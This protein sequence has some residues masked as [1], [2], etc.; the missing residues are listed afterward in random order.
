MSQPEWMTKYNEIGQKGEEG[1]TTI[2]GDG[3][4]ATSEVAPKRD[5]LNESASDMAK[6]DVGGEDEAAAPA[7]APP[8]P[9]PK[10]K[11]GGFLFG[12]GGAEK[13]EEEPKEEEA[14]EINSTDDDDDAAAMFASAANDPPAPAPAAEEDDAAA[15]FANAAG[16]APAPAAEDDDAAAMFASA[17]GDAPAPAPAAEDDDAAAM[18]ANAGT[19]GDSNDEVIEEE[20]D[21]DGIEEE[22]VGEGGDDKKAI[23]DWRRQRGEEP[24]EEGDATD[25]AA[26]YA[27]ADASATETEATREYP[28][29]PPIDENDNWV[30]QSQSTEEVMVDDDG[31]EI[32]EEDY[33]VDE[34]GNEIL[35]EGAVFVD[36]DGNEI[37]E[38]VDQSPMEEEVVE[39]EDKV[40]DRDLSRDLDIK[41]TKEPV[42]LE[43][44]R[45]LLYKTPQK[46][47]SFMSKLLPCFV[48]IAIIV[49]AL[50]V[51]ILV[52]E[53]DVDDRNEL[54]E[55]PTPAF[56]P[57]GPTNIG[58]IDVAETTPLSAV[59]GDCNIGAFQQPHVI[60]QCACG[61]TI[62]KIA[63][64]V[65]ARYETLVPWVRTMFDDWEESA[66]SCSPRNQ[67]LVW[68][69]TGVNLGGEISDT[70]RK[71]RYL[72]G[73]LYIQQQGQGWNKKMNWLTEESLCNWEGVFCDDEESVIG[74]DVQDNNLKNQLTNGIGMYDF[75]EFVSFRR[76][77]LNGTIP[78]EL[79]ASS[80]L[81]SID[82]YDNSF[83][84]EI[85]SFDNDIPL[86]T[87]HVGKN[88]LSGRIYESI[89]N[90]KS[91]KRLDLSHNTL[92]GEIPMVLFDLAL[93]EL[94]INSNL[95]TGTIHTELGTV[96][97][98]TELN[99]GGNPF[100]GSLPL[101]IGS[102]T[103]LQEFVVKDAPNIDGRIP[104]SFGLALRNLIKVVISG[105][106]INGNVPETFGS[107]RGLEH[108]EFSK[109]RLRGDLS[110][111]FGN[112]SNLKVM[113]LFDND[114]VGSIPTEFGQ[115][116]NL[117]ALLL[118]DNMITGEI[119]SQ[120]SN[121][122][123][124]KQLTLQ[125]NNMS[126]RSPDGVCALRG[127]GLNVFVVDCPI[128]VG[129]SFTGVVCDTPECCTSCRF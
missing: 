65:L 3:A 108:M 77:Q 109:N 26:A 96:T 95:L 105:T 56:L 1:V 2:E 100:T 127:S 32:I 106:S 123:N 87:L 38:E 24:G 36:E 75:L 21:D 93:E 39:E 104:A 94:D 58:I 7:P 15:M 16:P 34:D 40:E 119:P 10:P 83:F 57:L 28:E 17:S 48:C 90:A 51:A 74:I 116:T 125:G 118:E 115:L 9:A 92:N 82:L 53:V 11:T 60:D 14:A 97:T 50:L 102:L 68:F 25:A 79:F 8:A 71:D 37:I 81:K 63:P 4:I 126:G 45:D 22:V 128:R 69:S 73:L 23:E 112:L 85:P 89:G 122:G 54:T 121:M 33:I 129:D 5:S 113:D 120:L 110:P 20:V 46:D 41:E 18:F 31:N 30:P 13:K 19:G 44:Q 86:E 6:L 67:A 70:R 52:F 59:T 84:G 124:L 91:L 62:N 47:M 76:N 27:S 107:I 99:I 61:P 78:Q 35:E 72:S 49:A 103:N 66:S 29:S 64:D 43:A 114:I 12:G 117:E 111:E 42:D 55:S 101:E 88:S 80:T 98:L